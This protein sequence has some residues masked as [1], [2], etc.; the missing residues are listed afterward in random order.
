MLILRIKKA[1]ESLNVFKFNIKNGHQ[2]IVAI[3]YENL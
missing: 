3:E 1:S 2:I